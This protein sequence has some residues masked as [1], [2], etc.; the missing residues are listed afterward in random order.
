[1]DFNFTKVQKLERIHTKAQP[2]NTL[3]IQSKT[4]TLS[5]NL[6]PFFK[7]QETT[8]AGRLGVWAEM[9][10][11]NNSRAIKIV[12]GNAENGYRFSIIPSKWHHQLR[13]ST[14]RSV[15]RI[16][17]AEGLYNLVQSP[18]GELIFVLGE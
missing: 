17:P 13:V 12:E 10:F 11:D 8:E 6:L 4:I 18:E 14:P 2:D 3:K 5:E 16:A 9:Y 1:M 7:N 15:K